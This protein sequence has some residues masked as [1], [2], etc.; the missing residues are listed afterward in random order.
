MELSTEEI[1]FLRERREEIQRELKDLDRPHLS[2]QYHDSNERRLDLMD[3][4]QQVETEL[5]RADAS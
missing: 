3:E 1:K 5:Q 4:L 2:P